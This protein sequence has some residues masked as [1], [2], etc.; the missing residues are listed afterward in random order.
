MSATK[1]ATVLAFVCLLLIG[2]AFASSELLYVQEG[3]NL[4]TYTAN[5]TTAKAT[6][7]NT[8][9][10]RASPTYPIQIFHAPT[11][12]FLYILGFTSATQE[13]FWVHTLASN[14][15]PTADPIQVLPVKPALSQFVFHP[16]G[17]FG[18]AEYS[19]VESSTTCNGPS[20][21]SDIVSYTVDTTTGKLNNTTKPVANFPDNCSGITYLYG[22]NS[23]G[24][25]LYTYNY[26]ANASYGG[27]DLVYSYSTINI[28][29]G[30]LGPQV[31]F[32]DDSLSPNGERSAFANTL[33]AQSYEPIGGPNAINIYPNAVFPAKPIISCTSSMLQI[34]GDSIY[35]SDT[36]SGVYFDP[37]GKNLFVLDGTIN[38]TPILHV[39][40]AS[41]TLT[42]TGSSLPGTVVPVFSHDGRMVYAIANDVV[43]AD[44]FN[45]ATG[46]LMATSGLSQSNHY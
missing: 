16:S 7:I 3:H 21:Y 45:P 46:E 42:G 27:A 40:L 14:G 30:S 41:D 38:E 2:S 36:E 34:C 15:A 24:T 31:K 18:Y 5:S 17:N 39:N 10:M 43:L 26:P 32:W 33:I 20:Y 1:S 12:Q 35:A 23:T 22:L 13:Y 28:K 25:K 6:R 9:W 29:T 37:S 19:W 4:V 11:T 8:L 44:V